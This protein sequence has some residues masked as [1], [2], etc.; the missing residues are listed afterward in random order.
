[1]VLISE[2]R[3]QSLN[4]DQQATITEAVSV[5]G[6][7]H[8]NFVNNQEKELIT[9]FKSEGVNITYPD[10][11]PFR[12]AML[13]IYKDFDKKIGKQLVEELSDI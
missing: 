11:A 13:P 2:D 4:K 8:T 1:M 5:A 6:K 9:F 7:R 10:L 3:W 12:E